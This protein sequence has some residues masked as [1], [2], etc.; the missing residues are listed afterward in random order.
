MPP[1]G[2]MLPFSEVFGENVL[3]YGRHQCLPY[4]KNALRTEIFKQQFVLP[5][6][7]YQPS[8]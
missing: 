4:S 7:Y 8:K 5:G 2:K 1:G 3:L 6:G